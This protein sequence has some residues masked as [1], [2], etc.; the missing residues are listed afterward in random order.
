MRSLPPTRRVRRGEPPPRARRAGRLPPRASGS[1]L[2]PVPPD[3]RGFQKEPGIAAVD[4]DHSATRPGALAC[5]GGERRLLRR[6]FEK[7]R[8]GRYVA[9]KLDARSRPSPR[10]SRRSIA[11]LRSDSRILPVWLS[12]STTSTAPP[13]PP[14]RRRSRRSTSVCNRPTCSTEQR[15]APIKHSGISIGDDEPLRELEQHRAELARRV[16]RHQRVAEPLPH[17][18]DGLVGELVAIH[19]PLLEHSGGSAALMSL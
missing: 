18:V 16:Q 9:W 19:V 3:R 7:Q 6:A 2:V 15:L 13:A 11:G 14:R 10:P 1:H 8:V 12:R 4:E 5:N 17:L